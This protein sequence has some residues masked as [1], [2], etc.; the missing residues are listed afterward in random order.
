MRSQEAVAVTLFKRG[1]S[2]LDIANSTALRK[3]RDK[4][5]FWITREY[6]EDAIREA[7]VSSTKKR[8]I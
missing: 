4:L 7:L 3:V 1:D 2:V 8:G 6:V 5:G